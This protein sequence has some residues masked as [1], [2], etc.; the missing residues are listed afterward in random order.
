MFSSLGHIIVSLQWWWLEI[1]WSD[2]LLEYKVKKKV[3][4]IEKEI[5]CI[6]DIM[7]LCI[8]K[9]EEN[10]VIIIKTNLKKKF[11]K[12]YGGASNLKLNVSHGQLEQ[13]LYSLLYFGR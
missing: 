7:Y 12:H 10:D 6:R 2:V 3:R 5:E 9:N 8:F 1:D 4:E 13:F 11:K